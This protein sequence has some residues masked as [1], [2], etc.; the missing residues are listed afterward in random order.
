MTRSELAEHL[1][2]NVRARRYLS[3]ENLA[4]LNDLD[5]D[6]IIDNFLNMTCGDYGK[7]LSES[8]NVEQIIAESHNLMAFAN[9]HANDHN[10]T[11]V[12]FEWPS[13]IDVEGTGGGAAK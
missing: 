5:D 10:F 6:L 8:L 3:P 11:F 7:K 1:R 9:A 13:E 12:Q 2:Q 4:K